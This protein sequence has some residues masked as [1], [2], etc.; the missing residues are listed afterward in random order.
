MVIHA[1]GI[2]VIETETYSRPEKCH[3][4][5]TFDGK[6][7]GFSTGIKTDEPLV[8]ITAGAMWLRNLIAE[9]TGGKIHVKGVAVFPGWYIENTPE[10]RR[11]E[12]WVLNP[13]AL[14]AFIANQNPVL[15]PDKVHRVALHLSRYVRSCDKQSHSFNPT[16]AQRI[17]KSL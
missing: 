15:S 4:T 7:L 12:I 17:N 16:Q 11:S 5:I 3:P 2:Y 6:S 1:S 10:A 14:P 9:S 13:K 8:Q